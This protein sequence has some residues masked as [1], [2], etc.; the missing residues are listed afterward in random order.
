MGIRDLLTQLSP[1]QYIISHSIVISESWYVA[2]ICRPIKVHGKVVD[3]WRRMLS[4]VASV[5]V[6]QRLWGGGTA[7]SIDVYQ[8]CVLPYCPL[9]SFQLYTEQ[10]NWIFQCITLDSITRSIHVTT[11]AMFSL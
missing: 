1:Y 4:F 6:F 5:C 10:L 9:S 8:P 11:C 2:D 7:D 3:D